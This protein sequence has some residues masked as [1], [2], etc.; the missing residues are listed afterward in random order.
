MDFSS[1]EFKIYVYDKSFS[2]VYISGKKKLISCG[3]T[4]V[5]QSSFTSERKFKKLHNSCDDT[6]PCSS[7]KEAQEKEYFFFKPFSSKDG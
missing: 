4:T 3:K 7:S 2:S 1:I 5:L 6:K